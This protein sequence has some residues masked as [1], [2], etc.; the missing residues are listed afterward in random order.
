VEI[1]K[2]GGRGKPMLAGEFG[3]ALS[4]NVAKSRNL[5]LCAVAVGWNVGVDIEAVRPDF[6][7]D[8]IAAQ[9]FSAAEVRALLTLHPT[10]RVAAFFRCWTRKEAYLKA[11]GEGIAF[12]LDHFT[13]SLDVENPALLAVDGD[14]TAG[15]RWLLRA[16]PIDAGYEAALAIDSGGAV[17]RCLR[18][19]HP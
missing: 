11:Q 5:A 8:A 13:V 12:G 10:L 16:L 9:H 19:R 17:V 7:T 4:F 3:R 6:A 2:A 18:W 14:P 1:A 15:G